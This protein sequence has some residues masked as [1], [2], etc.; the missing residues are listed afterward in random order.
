MLF[1]QTK[2]I[3]HQN[4]VFKGFQT[5]FHLLAAESFAGLQLNHANHYEQQ[6]S[7]IIF[8]S[9]QILNYLLVFL[10]I[11]KTDLIFCLV[12]CGKVLEQDTLSYCHSNWKVVIAA[13]S[14]KGETPFFV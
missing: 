12:D 8:N 3:L 2:A 9:Q 4:G 7:R 14:S 1:G 10:F 11:Y 13:R 6:F 5:I